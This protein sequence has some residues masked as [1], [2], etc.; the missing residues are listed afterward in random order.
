M[1]FSGNQKT[2]IGELLS[3]RNPPLEH[4]RNLLEV[5]SRGEE[6][7]KKNGKKIQVKVNMNNLVVI[8]QVEKSW[9]RGSCQCDYFQT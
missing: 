1:Y 2:S 5:L 4:I 7:E 3:S 8:C 9:K 6:E